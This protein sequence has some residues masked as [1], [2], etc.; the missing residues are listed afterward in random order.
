MPETTKI[1]GRIT[2]TVVYQNTV[3]AS[4]SPLLNADGSIDQGAVSEY[5]EFIV[6]VLEIFDRHD[7]EVIEEAESNY[8]HSIYYSFV[9]HDD[10]DNKDYKYILFV[11]ISDHSVRESSKVGRQKYYANHANQLKEP[12]SK[13][14][15]TWKF[16]E[17]IV[18]NQLFD[19]YEDALALVEHRLDSL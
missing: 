2:I 5:E 4:I 12:K 7:F 19:S 11:R 13:R 15:Q 6:N 17:I 8:S 10:Y 18:N 14:K 3:T 1:I 16:K 9:K